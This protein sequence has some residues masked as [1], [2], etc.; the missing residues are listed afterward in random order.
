M[1]L[2]RSP[3]GNLLK[4]RSR[5]KTS[6]AIEKLMD[7]ARKPLPS[8]ETDRNSQY[9]LRKSAWATVSASALVS[10][11]AQTVPWWR[12]HRPWMSPP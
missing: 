1:I 3:W 6:A 9:L 4:L 5:G 8:F 7:L 12:E 11:S 10:A 2:T